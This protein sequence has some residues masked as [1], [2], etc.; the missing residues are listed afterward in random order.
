M[1]KESER[2]NR[3]LIKH[4][5]IFDY[6]QDEL[7]LQNGK[8]AV[9]DIIEHKGAAG[10]LAIRDDG[11]IVLVRQYRPAINKITLEIPAGGLNIGELGDTKQAALRELQEE[12]GYKAADAQFL[13]TINT[14]LAFCNEKIDIYFADKLEKTVQNLDEDEFVEVEAYGLSELLDM[15]KDGKIN[16]SKTICAI[17]AYALSKK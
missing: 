10:I 1:I 9:Y 11:K 8:K 13:M 6:Y 7:L 14:T 5:I 12:T 17:Q 3:T 4:G 15:I 2:L 16:D